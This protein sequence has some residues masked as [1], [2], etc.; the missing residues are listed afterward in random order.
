MATVNSLVGKVRVELGDLGKS[1]VTQFIADGTTNRFRLHYAP[2]DGTGVVVFK[3]NVNISDACSVEESTGILVTDVLPA[4]GDEFTVSGNYYRYFTNAEMVSLITDAVNMHVNGHVDSS[5]RKITIDNLPVIDEYP[6]AVYAVTLALYT[7]ATDAAFDIDVQA[8]DGV[9][10][11]RAERYRQLMEMIQTRQEQ[12]RDLCVQLGLGMYKIDVFSLRRVS[13]ATGRYVPVYT[14]QEVDDRS[15]PQRVHDSAPTYGSKPTPWPTEA[16]DLT[17]YQ[18]RSF[19]TQVTI[20]GNW[21]NYGFI[22]NLLN[23]RGSVLVVQHI[24]LTRTDASGSS[25]STTLTLSLTADQ[26]MTLAERTYWSI[27]SVDNTSNV[28]V[29]QKGGN[30]ITVRTSTVVL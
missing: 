7:L 28:Q 21:T 16:G 10:I 3:N 27:S 11:P 20:P 12:Y 2:L 9:T 17:A 18:G 23:Q 22:A 19:T 1:F 6:V 15:Y 4:D 24:T 30:F 25:P 13:K 5:G 26:T 8:P 29:E 14:P